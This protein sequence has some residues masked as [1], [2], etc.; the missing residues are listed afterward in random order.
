MF[1]S[2]HRER[3]RR[4]LLARAAADPLITGAAVTG[5][6]AGGTADR[7]SDIDLFFGVARGHAVGEALEEWSA[8]AYRELG[9]LHHFDLHSGPAHYRAFLLGDLLEIDLGFAPAADFGPVGDGGFEV[10]FGDPAA[11]RPVPADPGH[12]IGL[13]WHHALHARVGIERASWWAAEYWISALRDH[14]L[15]LACLRL[16]LPAGHAKGAHRLPADVT[17]PL[18]DALVRDLDPAELTRALRAAIRCLL[19]EVRLHDPSAAERLRAPLAELADPDGP[20]DR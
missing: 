9:A 5:S 12:L 15:A 16:G 2:D 11:R 20:D 3:V 4:S 14:T 7:W 18:S 19:A 8:F 13:A 6:Q 1:T 10:V 17:G